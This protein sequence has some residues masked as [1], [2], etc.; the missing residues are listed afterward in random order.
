MLTVVV[1]VLTRSRWGQVKPVTKC[2]AVS[3]Y[4]H[5]LFMGYAS[6]IILFEQPEVVTSPPT[7]TFQLKNLTERDEKSDKS[8]AWENSGNDQLAKIATPELSRQKNP[9]HENQVADATFLKSHSGDREFI[10]GE[11]LAGNLAQDLSHEKSELAIETPESQRGDP[12]KGEPS[13]AKELQASEL[14]GKAK[15]ESD[16]VRPNL[17][18]GSPKL[19]RKATEVTPEIKHTEVTNLKTPTKL[20]TEENQLQK[21]KEL[22]TRSLA[23][24]LAAADDQLKAT[25]NK[26]QKNSSQSVQ[27]PE[28]FVSEKGP[29]TPIQPKE[30]E[31]PF[32]TAAASTTNVSKG[33]LT[34]VPQSRPGDGKAQASYYL[35][36]TTDPEKRL[37]I[38]KQF[39]GDENTEQAVEAGLK[40]LASVQRPDGSWNAREHGGGREDKV[41]DHDRQGAGANAESALTAL[42]VLAFMGA[43]HTHLKGVYRENVQHGLEYLLKIQKQDGNLAGEATL[44]ARMYCHG[45]ASLALS[46][47][48]AITGDQRIKPGLQKALD[49]TIAS[50]HAQTGGWRYMPGDKGDMSQFGWQ[51]MSLQSAKNGG[52]VVPQAT[53]EKM[54]KFLKNHSVG[55]HSG[56][57]SYR[58]GEKATP[59]M[60]AEA[61]SC[62]IFLGKMLKPE[63]TQEG[64]DFL[65]KKGVKSRIKN[66]YYWYYGTVALHQ[67][68]NEQWKKWNADI[69][70]E[71]LAGQST[72]GLNSGSWPA[73]SLWGGYGGRVYSTAMGTL[74]LEVYYRYLPLY[75]RTAFSQNG[76][77]QT[78]FR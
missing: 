78:V 24:Q 55:I 67:L 37:A 52:L 36:R 12:T 62:R 57:A 39:G 30:I 74:T 20:L 54:E 25:Q 61:L 33:V 22:A 63:T 15:R 47:A 10:Q 40:W 23:E 44:Y 28:D 56:L 68:Q 69:K 71:L 60:T 38:A 5:T 73:D 3:I 65:I 45:M 76:G 77:K 34:L 16:E 48:Y 11:E 35:L 31:N 21:L 75:Q 43:G 53:Y 4:I 9:L 46:E 13:G 50:Q 7:L 2:L 58:E 70:A 1:L 32:R 18:I 6:A 19:Q 8:E 72:E 41:L 27:N 64:S 59:S 14:P 66:Y 26:H 42:S 29:I 49:Y 51:V 17:A